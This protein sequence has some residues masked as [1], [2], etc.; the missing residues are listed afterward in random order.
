MLRRR[1]RAH[2]LAQ[3]DLGDLIQ[4]QPAGHEVPTLFDSQ[5]TVQ[6]AG[7][8]MRAEP[9]PARFR[10]LELHAQLG[11]AQ[12]TQEH[13][14]PF[15]AERPAVRRVEGRAFVCRYFGGERRARAAQRLVLRALGLERSLAAQALAVRVK[16]QA[17]S[18]GT[19]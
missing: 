1:R 2:E 10:P 12:L 6:S 11:I 8:R 5:A 15:F 13:Q 4:A 14:H 18:P 9:K 16:G 3:R 19:R 7:P 17:R